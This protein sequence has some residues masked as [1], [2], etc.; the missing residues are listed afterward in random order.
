MHGLLVKKEGSQ[1]LPP[2]CAIECSEE[3]RPGYNS[4]KA[5]EYEDQPQTLMYRWSNIHFDFVN[6]LFERKN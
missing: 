2:I 4:M 5:H 6:T 1:W 3:A